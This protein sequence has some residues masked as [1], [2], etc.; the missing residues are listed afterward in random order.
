MIRQTG[1]LDIDRKR[2][3]N[4]L[5]DT[6]KTNKAAI[7]GAATIQQRVMAG[8]FVLLIHSSH[9]TANGQ[10]TRKLRLTADAILGESLL[11]GRRRWSKWAASRVGYTRADWAGPWMDEMVQAGLPGDDFVVLATNVAMNEWLQRPATMLI[12]VGLSTFY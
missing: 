7:D 12:L 3:L 2:E 9:R 11:K 6:L 5:H 4:E 8:F 10:R 1:F